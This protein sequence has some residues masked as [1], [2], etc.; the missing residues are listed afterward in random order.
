MAA[1]LH[2]A[3]VT[4]RLAGSAGRLLLG[5]SDRPGDVDVEVAACDAAAAANAL[6]LPIPGPVQGGGWSSHRSEGMVDGV[7]VDLSA[8]LEVHGPGGV[9]RA[10]DAAT[11][12]TPLGGGWVQVVAPGESVARAVVAGDVARERRARA[13]LPADA[14][15]A[16]AYAESRITAAAS[17]AR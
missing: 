5:G 10:D 12:A 16:L 4:W 13:D 8:G 6:G 17:A 3:G 9:L 7:T 11:V 2:A 15:A 1:R 14:A